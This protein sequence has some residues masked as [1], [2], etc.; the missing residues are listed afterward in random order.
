MVCAEHHPLSLQTVQSQCFSPL[1]SLCLTPD[2]RGERGSARRSDRQFGWHGGCLRLP[3]P[4]GGAWPGRG[5]GR[6]PSSHSRG[7]Q[8]V[9]GGRD[10]GPISRKKTSILPVDGA[11]FLF[12]LLDNIKRRFHLTEGLWPHVSK[13]YYPHLRMLSSPQ[14]LSCF[15]LVSGVRIKKSVAAQKPPPVEVE[16]FIHA[17]NT[18]RSPSHTRHTV[19][20]LSLLPWYLNLCRVC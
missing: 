6:Q 3:R 9:P 11:V 5:R 19:P 12:Y 17:S 18:S 13:P 4:R 20:V 1:F 7:L 16:P 10:R 15:S 14:I 2:R 8:P